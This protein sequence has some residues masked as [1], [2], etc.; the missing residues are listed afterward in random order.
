MIAITSKLKDY[1]LCYHINK[2]TGTDFKKTDDYCLALFS[3]SEPLQFSQYCYNPVDTETEYYLIANQV[4]CG[5]LI[6][7][8]GFV[9][10][11]ILIKNHYD[12][13]ELHGML[14]KLKHIC[15][16]ERVLRVDPAKLQS[17]ENLLF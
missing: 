3:G 11:F 1:R 17:N 5:L 14:N 15:G 9:D 13:E 2:E 12:D 6:P 8:M 4:S 16:L 10:Y 7:E